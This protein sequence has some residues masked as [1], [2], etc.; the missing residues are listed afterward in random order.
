MG[1]YVANSSSVTPA[2]WIGFQRLSWK[3]GTYLPQGLHHG[4]LAN[5]SALLKHNSSDSLPREKLA[6]SALAAVRSVLGT[7]RRSRIT[8]KSLGHEQSGRNTSRL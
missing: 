3:A 1:R 5:G 7:S 6:K 8:K 2:D 4:K